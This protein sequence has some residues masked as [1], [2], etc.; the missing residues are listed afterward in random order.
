[1]NVKTFAAIPRLILLPH[2]ANIFLWSARALAC[3]PLLILYVESP[4]R[5]IRRKGTARQPATVANR[6]SLLTASRIA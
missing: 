1:V 2:M 4:R 5:Q 3:G 6:T